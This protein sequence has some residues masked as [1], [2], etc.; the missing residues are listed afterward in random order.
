ML[1]SKTF[2]KMDGFCKLIELIQV[3]GIE[4]LSSSS[5]QMLLSV[6]L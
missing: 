5:Q 3:S 6:F 2:V 1:L 4:Y